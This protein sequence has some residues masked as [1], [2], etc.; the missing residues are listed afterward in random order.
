M[1][2]LLPL[3]AIALAG[4]TATPPSTNDG[5]VVLHGTLGNWSYQTPSGDPM[6]SAVIELAEPIAVPGLPRPASRV[7]LLLS[8]R[9]FVSWRKFVGHSASVTCTLSV[10]S[11]WGYPHA[12]CS[13]S[14]IQVAP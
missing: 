12:S 5:V 7:E 2:T 8:E 1:R 9:H 11:L 14:D 13:P 6:Q 3:V 10:A 4:C